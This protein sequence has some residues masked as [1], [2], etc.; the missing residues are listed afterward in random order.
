MMYNWNIHIEYGGIPCVH[1]VLFYVPLCYLLFSMTDLYPGQI[2]SKYLL[3]SNN[4]N[5]LDLV[6]ILLFILYFQ[7]F[8]ARLKVSNCQEKENL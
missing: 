1:N 6:I 7:L 5:N 3:V 4:A 8:N 2:L